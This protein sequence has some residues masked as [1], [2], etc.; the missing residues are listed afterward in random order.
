MKDNYHVTRPL[1]LIKSDHWLGR[2]D[3]LDKIHHFSRVKLR[4]PVAVV[5]MK[6]TWHYNF[7]GTYLLSL[8]ADLS[9]T[10]VI[11]DMVFKLVSPLGL[12]VFPRSWRCEGNLTTPMLGEHGQRGVNTLN[13]VIQFVEE[14]HTHHLI[15]GATAPFQPSTALMQS[16]TCSV[17]L[18]LPKQ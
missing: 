12:K 3:D 11:T 17:E 16:D 15:D 6:N 1:L 13:H 2:D 7:G 14:F 4:V 9:L 8:A 18:N 5:T 10:R